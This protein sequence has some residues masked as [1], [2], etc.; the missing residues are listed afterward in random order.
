MVVTTQVIFSMVYCITNGESSTCH[1]ITIAGSNVLSSNTRWIW[2]NQN[3]VFLDSW[4][5]RDK[6][7]IGQDPF[8]IN[9]LGISPYLTLVQIRNFQV[10]SIIYPSITFSS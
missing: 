6:R 9:I 4:I 7:N 1:S 2:T 5:V 10:I 8:L 3:E